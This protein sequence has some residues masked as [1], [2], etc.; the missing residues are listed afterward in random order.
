MNLRTPSPAHQ[1][2][3]LPKPVK[4]ED[5]DKGRCEKGSKNSADGH[6]CGGWHS[7]SVHLASVGH[8]ALT[9]R[10]LDVDPGWTWEP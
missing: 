8:A 1:I 3:F 4:K 7:K 9:D 5:Q 10:L 2:S 6:Y